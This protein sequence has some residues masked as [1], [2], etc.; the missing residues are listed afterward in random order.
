M[1][2][3]RNI[4]VAAEARESIGNILLLCGQLLATGIV[5]LTGLFELLTRGRTGGDQLLLPL[6]LA[7]LVGDG[8]LGRSGIGPLLMIGR[9]HRVNLQTFGGE[10][11]LGLLD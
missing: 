6:E 3:D 5:G 2:I 7:L 4:K 9:L 11:R 8:G 10:L 1:L